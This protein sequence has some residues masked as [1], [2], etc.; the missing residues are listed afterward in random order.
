MSTYFTV[1]RTRGTAWNPAIPMRTQ[2]RWPEHADFMNALVTD[3]FVVLGGPLGSGEEFLL[4]VHALTEDVV[5]SALLRIRG[6]DQA[7]L[8]FSESISGLSCLMVDLG[9]SKRSNTVV[10]S[11]ERARAQTR[12]PHRPRC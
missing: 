7:C 3:G 6:A 9:R 10:A 1:H 11:H 8:R 5:R 12:N 2:A 4:V